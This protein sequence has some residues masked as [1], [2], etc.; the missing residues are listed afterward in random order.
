MAAGNLK[1][2]NY[3]PAVKDNKGIKTAYPVSLSGTSATLNVGGT[4][5][6]TGASTFTGVATFTAA[7]VFNGGRT[8]PV[9]DL[10]SATAAPTA[11]QS[12]SIFLFDR[13]AGV[14]ATLPAPSVGLEYTFIVV[15]TVTSNSYKIITDAGTTFLTGSLLAASDNLASKSFIG[16]G[17]THLAVTQAAASSNSTGGIIGSQ[18]TVRCVTSTLWEVTGTVIASATPATPF[19]TS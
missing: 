5:A 13:A 11:A 6:V 16:N 1:I 12:G 8:A 19:A 3:V 15:T 2:E 10:T 18:V 7:P 9:V 14:T 4:L 17:T